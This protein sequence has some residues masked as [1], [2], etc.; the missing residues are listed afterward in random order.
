[1]Y[2]D[3]I[4]EDWKLGDSDYPETWLF[5]LA[6]DS[7][8]IQARPLNLNHGKK[9][10]VTFAPDYDGYGPVPVAK[11]EIVKGL[12]TTLDWLF[13]SHV[14]NVR[15]AI[16]D[17]FIVDPSLLNINDLKSPG[18]G[19]LIRM[20]KSAWGRGVEN[21]IKQFNVTDITKNHM[22]DSA[23]IGDLI[24]NVGGSVDAISGFRRKTAER[25]T[26]EEVR[27][28][29]SSGLSRLE[30][31]AK[32]ASWMAFQDLGMML[33][34]HTQQLMSKE[35]YVKAVGNWADVLAA[36]YGVAM[37][38]RIMVDP[39]DILVA[40]DVVV[41]D[42]SV[43]GANFNP[44]VWA[45]YLPV[46]LQDPEIRQSLDIVRLMKHIILN[47]GGKDVN[48]FDRKQ[49]VQ[50]PQTPQVPQVQAQVMPDQQVQQQVQAGNL[51]P[52]EQGM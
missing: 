3:I 5:G 1:M 32:V 14:A 18:P 9:P 48:F 23:I 26:A 51:V 47:T 6:A 27:R 7:I 41:K 50:Q 8:V 20:R 13:N 12:Q 44:E 42:G 17:M 2:I 43:P 25:V 37:G 4:P 49:P 10:V 28:D 22:G 21:A 31:T 45:Q 36:D 34:S 19:K 16:N 40:Y 38:D 24:R 30:K 29:A 15:K 35:T 52:A 33:A 46:I 39:M 11:L